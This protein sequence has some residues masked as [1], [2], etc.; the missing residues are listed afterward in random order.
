MFLVSWWIL[1]MI[2]IGCS[3]RPSG[4]GTT[5]P[6]TGGI[7]AYHLVTRELEPSPLKPWRV[8]VSHG[9]RSSGT[10]TPAVAWAGLTAG[11]PGR[12]FEQ[13]GLN[14]PKR[15]AVSTSVWSSTTVALPTR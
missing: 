1:R 8:N 7:H 3:S 11:Q 13:G 15:M 14:V 6:V 4:E 10:R 5:Y 9:E 12:M 2:C